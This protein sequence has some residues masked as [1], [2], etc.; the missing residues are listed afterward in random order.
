MLLGLGITFQV[1]LQAVLNICVVI[2]TIPNTGSACPFS[3]M[4]APLF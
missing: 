4:A 1:G 2:N 3:V